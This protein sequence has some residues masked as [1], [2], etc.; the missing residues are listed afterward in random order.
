V[1]D[2][3]YLWALANQDYAGDLQAM[4]ADR[5][6]RLAEV[7]VRHRAT[8]HQRL[9]T[10]HRTMLR[11]QQD[12][13]DQLSERGPNW[14]AWRQRRAAE[15]ALDTRSFQERYGFRCPRLWPKP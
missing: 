13:L 10:L 14:E 3:D 11:R 12:V 5:I 7:P 9:T 8:V 15:E 4:Y 1:P 2:Y 6:V